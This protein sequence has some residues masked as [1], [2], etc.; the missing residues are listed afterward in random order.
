MK[1][2]FANEDLEI[3]LTSFIDDKENV[4]FGAKEIAEILGYSNI[5]QTI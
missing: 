2:K 3:E 5:R 4:W 1:K